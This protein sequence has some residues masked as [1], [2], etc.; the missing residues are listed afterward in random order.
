MVA[1]AFAFNGVVRR[2]AV[3]FGSTRSLLAV[4]PRSAAL[5]PGAARSSGVTPSVA[6]S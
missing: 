2:M 5:A 3:R 1:V 6:P 4:T